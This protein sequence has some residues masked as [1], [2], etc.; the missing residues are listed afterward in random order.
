MTPAELAAFE[1][2]IISTCTEHERDY[3]EDGYQRCVVTQ[4]YFIKFDS[5][6][7]IPSS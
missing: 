2:A 4:G 3:W 1:A 6:D 5:Y 7:S